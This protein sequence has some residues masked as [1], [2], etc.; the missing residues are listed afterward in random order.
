MQPL[1]PLLSTYATYFMTQ[2]QEFGVTA[3]QFI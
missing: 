1:L 2:G 3:I